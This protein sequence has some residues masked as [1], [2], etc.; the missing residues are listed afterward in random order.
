LKINPTRL[1]LLFVVWVQI[2]AV[3]SVQHRTLPNWKKPTSDLAQSLKANSSR[4]QLRL[5]S[6]QQ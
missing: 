1:L 3:S 2:A 4:S 5:L 6:W